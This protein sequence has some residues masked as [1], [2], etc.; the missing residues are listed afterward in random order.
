MARESEEATSSSHV[1]YPQSST[2]AQLFCVLRKDFRGKERLLA[3]YK[4]SS[5]ITGGGVVTVTTEYSVPRW[6][7]T[8]STGNAHE[9]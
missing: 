2:H 3:V 1:T 8:S 6:G 7:Q 4:N 5:Q 9:F